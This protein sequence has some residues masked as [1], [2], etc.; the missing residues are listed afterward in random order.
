MDQEKNINEEVLNQEEVIETAE[1][2]E[3][4]TE[5]PVEEVSRPEV[6]D[7]FSEEYEEKPK[8]KK[9]CKLKGIFDFA[10]IAL[11]LA[12]VLVVS[13][14][15]KFVPVIITTAQVSG[16]WEYDMGSTET[17]EM[18]A[19]VI[20]DGGKMTLATST[21]GPMFACDYK[22][23][24]GGKIEIVAGQNDDMMASFI[25]GN[26]FS[27]KVDRDNI[28]F[29]PSMGGIYTWARTGSEEAKVIKEVMVL[30]DVSQ[31]VIPTDDYV[32]I[33]E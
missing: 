20:F 21:G 8:V 12:I 31:N 17:Q 14:L 25:S 29:S 6:Y 19:Y 10:S 3:E 16:V 5:A 1:F 4:V 22:I 28:Y 13:L 26:E 30:P 7:D 18:K 15:V 32:D 23:S 11:T 9:E 33:T 24:E 27:I 2:V